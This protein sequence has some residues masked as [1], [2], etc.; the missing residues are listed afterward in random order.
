MDDGERI[1]HYSPCFPVI[2]V[3]ATFIRAVSSMLS[4]GNSKLLLEYWAM[5]TPRPACRPGIV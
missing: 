5:I 3:I 2:R 1:R 4:F